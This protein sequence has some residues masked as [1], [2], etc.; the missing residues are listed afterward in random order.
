[1]MYQS[2]R[3]HSAVY[4]AALEQG[5]IVLRIAHDIAHLYLHC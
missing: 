4:Y 3:L 1:M 5:W 2:V